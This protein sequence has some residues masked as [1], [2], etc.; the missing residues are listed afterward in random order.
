MR[1]IIY[2]FIVLFAVFASCKKNKEKPVNCRVV[3]LT[4][5]PTG[6]NPLSVNFTYDD[7]GKLQFINNS[8]QTV[9]FTYFP[10]GFRLRI[11][12][13]NGWT[14]YSFIE[15][16]ASGK[17]VTKKDSVYNGQNL[18][19]T[20][21]TSFEYNAQGELI[22]TY[23]DN[24]PQ[25]SETFT[26]SSG[27]LV[28]YKAGNASYILDYY[29]DK[30]N[31][32]YSFIDL[33]LFVALGINPAKSKNLLKSLTSGGDQLVFNYEYDARGY[34]KEWTA[35]FLGTTETAIKTT[36]QVSCD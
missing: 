27:N 15:L 28:K 7:Q 25:A 33:Q 29:T 17:P 13:G 30:K 12:T 24:D 11:S 31:Q 2:L 20:Y 9:E 14:T 26:W 19:S 35:V 22:N 6:G 1:N 21:L 18:N 5:V 3:A 8:G 4:M 32:D 23:K 36:Q 34:I 16:T 10:N